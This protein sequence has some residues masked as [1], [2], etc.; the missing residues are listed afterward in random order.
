MVVGAQLIMSIKTDVKLKV[1]SI[2]NK[3]R[4]SYSKEELAKTFKIIV[5]WCING[6][7]EKLNEVV[8][9]VEK[10]IYNDILFSNAKDAISNYNIREIVASSGQVKVMKLIHED[11]SKYHIYKQHD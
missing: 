5:K 9:N 10:P 6:E 1:H 3:V 7:T 8:D 4:S 2:S 11:Q